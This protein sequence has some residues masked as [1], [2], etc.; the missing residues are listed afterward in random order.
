MATDTSS[1]DALLKDLLTQMT[2]LRHDNASLASA[3]DAINGR[4]NMLAGVK[5]VQDS[6]S[7]SS[8]RKSSVVSCAE[9]AE[10]KEAEETV[11]ALGRQY[12][13][14]PQGAVGGGSGDGEGV[15]RPSVSKTS[16]IILTSYPGQAGVDPLPMDWGNRDPVKRGPVVVSRHAGT[17]RR[18]NG[19]VYLI[20]SESMSPQDLLSANQF[21]PA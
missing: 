13:A 2:A 10:E 20:L 17:I 6:A 8:D 3:I 4:V 16:K 15:R 11:E 18:R 7:S 5:A 9:K 12:E 21:I 14:P 19:M 1:T